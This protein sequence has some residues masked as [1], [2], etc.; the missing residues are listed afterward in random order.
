VQ[1]QRLKS[2]VSA[3]S[4][5]CLMC[6]SL[7]VTSQRSPRVIVAEAPA[8]SPVVTGKGPAI[9]ATVGVGIVNALANGIVEIFTAWL[10][11]VIRA[12]SP[13]EPGVNN[14][15][16]GVVSSFNGTNQP[17]ASLQDKEAI[18]QAMASP[19]VQKQARTSKV[20]VRLVEVNENGLMLA[21]LPIDSTAKLASGKR[22]IAEIVSNSPGIVALFTK[23]GKGNQIQ[24]G[25]TQVI[26]AA[27]PNVLPHSEQSIILDDE[28]GVEEYRV[29]F[30]PCQLSGGAARTTATANADLKTLI[31]VVSKSAV[32]NAPKVG[33]KGSRV[34]ANNRNQVVA[35]R[36]NEV[37][38]PDIATKLPICSF[39]EFGRIKDS[40]WFSQDS[41]RT[42][43][44]DV[45]SLT[46]AEAKPNMRAI[47]IKFDVDHIAR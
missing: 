39:E 20:G 6:V 38:H 37:V 1:K 12:A 44:P 14:S 43:I 31:S 41:I 45:P 23:D 30:M 18:Q 33:A 42:P 19:E 5:A 25:D 15:A 10:R 11:P 28:V 21:A 13:G 46:V 3:L 7:P 40:Q 22:F 24:L 36:T 29:V 16:G 9:L 27:V 47:E 35:A 2:L 32:S 26:G 8:N 4:A 34:E 17:Q